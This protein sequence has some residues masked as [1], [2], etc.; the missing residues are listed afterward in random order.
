MDLDTKRLAQISAL[1]LGWWKLCDRLGVKNNDLIADTIAMLIRCY[2]E[3]HRHYHDLS[4]IENCLKKFQEVRYLCDFPNEV[5]MALWFHDAVYDVT[6]NDNESLSAI[7]CTQQ[8]MAMRV[9][10]KLIARIHAMILFTMHKELPIGNASFVV[11]M[12]FLL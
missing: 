5:E 8:L 3:R 4:H 1:R 12:A 10:P 9:S 11:D 6:R 7:F 2:S